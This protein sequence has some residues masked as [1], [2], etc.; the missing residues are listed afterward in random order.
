MALTH[1]ELHT[2]VDHSLQVCQVLKSSS[3]FFVQVYV[4]LNERLG[5][6]DHLMVLTVML[7]KIC[8][9]LKVFS[10]AEDVIQDSLTLFSVSPLG[11]YPFLAGCAV[12]SLAL[13]CTHTH[14]K[15]Y[16]GFL[17]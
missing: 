9:N 16:N 8:T 11:I 4:R 3:C 5:L 12:F 10:C 13:S 15:A 17:A 2:L 1:Y 14:T 6:R 7:T